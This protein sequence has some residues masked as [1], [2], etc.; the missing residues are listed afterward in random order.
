MKKIILALALVSLISACGTPTNT[1]TT[2]AD[3][4]KKDTTKVDT[5]VKVVTSV[6][7]DTT[8]K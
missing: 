2:P 5:T 3:T 7:P 4:T 1:G 6:K 8:K